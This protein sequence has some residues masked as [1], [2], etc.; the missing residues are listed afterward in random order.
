VLEVN[1]DGVDVALKALLFSFAF[2]RVRMLLMMACIR[3]DGHDVPLVFPVDDG[4]QARIMSHLLHVR[5]RF[6]ESS[7]YVKEERKSDSG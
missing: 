6:V 5:F 1:D 2:F 3:V 4:G 7:I